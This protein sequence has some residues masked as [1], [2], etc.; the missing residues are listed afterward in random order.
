MIQFIR[1]VVF[2]WTCF[3]S[4]V[5][6]SNLTDQQSNCSVTQD[7]N[8]DDW[9]AVQNDMK[10]EKHSVLVVVCHHAGTRIIIFGSMTPSGANMMG[11]WH[12]GLEPGTTSVHIVF[13]QINPCQLTWSLTFQKPW[14]LVKKWPAFSLWLTHPLPPLSVFSPFIEL[15]TTPHTFPSLNCHRIFSF[16]LRVSCQS[17][18][19]HALLDK[20][21][22]PSRLRVCVPVCFLRGLRCSCVWR[23][24]KKKVTASNGPDSEVGIAAGVCVRQSLSRACVTTLWWWQLRSNWKVQRSVPSWCPCHFVVLFPS[25]NFL[26]QPARGAAWVG[27]IFGEVEASHRD[28]RDGHSPLGALA[29]VKSRA[30]GNFKIREPASDTFE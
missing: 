1:P 19:L 28:L 27:R 17:L 21:K 5:S 22:T 23:G 16:I 13:K 15:D 20:S 11:Q 4:S 6:N 14:K 29:T 26:E 7:R 24:D 10:W 18:C 30:V 8:Y 25:L 3:F 2:H 9:K 12:E